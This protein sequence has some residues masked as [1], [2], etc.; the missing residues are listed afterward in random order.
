MEAGEPIAVVEAMMMENLLKAERDGTVGTIRV[1]PGESLGFEAVI[2]EFAR[3]RRD[4][5]VSRCG[6]RGGLA[7]FDRPLHGAARR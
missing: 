7:L 1:K 4:R 5:P 2:L 3:G 6:G